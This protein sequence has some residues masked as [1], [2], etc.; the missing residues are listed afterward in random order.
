MTKG[1]AADASAAPGAIPR[2]PSASFARLDGPVTAQS[3]AGSASGKSERRWQPRVS[4]RSSAERAI[5]RASGCGS[6]ASRCEPLGVAQRSRAMP[7]R[8]SGG[9]RES[10]VRQA[11]GGGDPRPAHRRL[12][13][14][15]EG[16]A[17]PEHE[18]LRQ[19]V[20]GQPVGAVHA[21]ARALA[22]GVQAAE[23]GAP[24][25]VGDDPADHVVRG[26]R[27]RDQVARGSRPARARLSD[28]VGEAGRVD[29]PH[30]EEHLLRLRAAARRS[31]AQPR[32][33]ER[34]R[35]R[36]AHR[37]HRRAARPRRARPPSPGSRRG[38][39]RS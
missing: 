3:S 20:R 13:E 27:D 11:A 14:R 15:G 30:V 23:R 33:A 17:A 39:R 31:P 32:R 35:P 37:R 28:D 34:A 38:P 36:S 12:V 10:R 8:G 26:R 2:P 18:A 19:R 29:A 16:R 1:I 9:L 22:H 4:R 21:R 25:I 6:A 5:A 7:E 24:A